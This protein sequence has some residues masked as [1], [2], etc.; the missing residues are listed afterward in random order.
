[1]LKNLIIILLLSV[2]T[3][4]S[5]RAE[6][7]PD[8]LLA[9]CDSALEACGKSNIAKDAVISEQDKIITLQAA[10]VT[11]FREEAS[12]TAIIKSPILWFAVGLTVGVIVSR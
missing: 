10:E 9:A 5:V 2:N 4:Q 3:I 11:K 6:A 7:L 1:M 12:S 8:T